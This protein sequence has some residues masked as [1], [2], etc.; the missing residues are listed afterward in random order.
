MYVA[1]LVTCLTV[2]GFARG[3]NAVVG[4]VGGRLYL[5]LSIAYERTLHERVDVSVGVGYWPIYASAYGVSLG[6]TVR[7]LRH[8][9]DDKGSHSL[10]L[11]GGVHA[12]RF[13][14]VDSNEGIS[15][16]HSAFAIYAG[17]A[18]EW[19]GDAVFRVGPY[20]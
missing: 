9:F 19:R 2:I 13:E 12:Q 15:D 17:M 16:W 8:A 5:P 6:A 3:P 18:Y 11:A 4:E 20:V 7:A 1:A 10:A 14:T